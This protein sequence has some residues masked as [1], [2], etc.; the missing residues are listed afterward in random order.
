MKKLK[1]A[2][3][4]LCA[5]SMALA[6]TACGSNGSSSSDTVYHVGICQ[7]IEHPALDLATQ[8]FQ[9]A[10]TEKLGGSGSI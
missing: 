3:S 10:L 2:L 1:Q 6:L 9:D 7:L 8:G 4:V 5:A